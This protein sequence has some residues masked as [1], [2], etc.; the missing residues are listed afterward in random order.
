MGRTEKNKRLDQWGKN[1]RE[2]WLAA[3][4][5]GNKVTGYFEEAK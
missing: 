3:T 5:K 2:Y 4:L 1:K